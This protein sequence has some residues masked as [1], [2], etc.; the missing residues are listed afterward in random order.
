MKE[1][2][3]YIDLKTALLQVREQTDTDP[4]FYRGAVGAIS[5][6][7]T[8]GIA[9]GLAKNGLNAQVVSIPGP[10]QVPDYNI[11]EVTSEAPEGSARSFVA[12]VRESTKQDAPSG[13]DRVTKEGVQIILEYIKTKGSPP[14]KTQEVIG[15][16]QQGS[17]PFWYMREWPLVH[18]QK[19]KEATTG[20]PGDGGGGDGGNGGSG[21]NGGGGGSDD[22]QAAQIIRGVPNST[23]VIGTAGV[24]AALMLTVAAS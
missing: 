18:W 13:G 20:P 16:Y 7:V 11:A 10:D 22:E 4:Q 12:N 2:W 1:L 19:V 23:V 15:E 3:T 5:T 21:G 24:T 14:D 17:Q 9:Q 8:D 6:K